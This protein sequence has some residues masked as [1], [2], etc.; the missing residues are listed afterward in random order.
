ML[1]GRLPPE[2]EQ[3]LGEM[4][5]GFHRLLRYLHDAVAKLAPSRDL[6]AGEPG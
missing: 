2:E 5:Y 1:R 3:A 4:L 6:D